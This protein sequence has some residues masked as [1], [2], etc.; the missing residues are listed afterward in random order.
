MKLLIAGVVMLFLMWM[1][2]VLVWGRAP[3]LTE[4]KATDEQAAKTHQSK[5]IQPKSTDGPKVDDA[6][7]MS[8]PCVQTAE[9]VAITYRAF[10]SQH[11]NAVCTVFR[12]FGGEQPP[13]R[14]SCALFQS[15]QVEGI[16]SSRTNYNF[17]TNGRLVDI[18]S[19]FHPDS[20]SAFQKVRVAL[21]Q[22]CGTPTMIQKREEKSSDQFADL[23][24]RL[25]ISWERAGY[26]TMLADRQVGTWFDCSV[27]LNSAFD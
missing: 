24:S 14:R 22:R 10:K 20:D 7:L 21:L 13:V 6:A 4:Q 1:V 19:W 3:S 11:P 2:Y 12:D 5:Q 16:T 18:S 9:S 23:A 27:V 15:V 17:D 8:K 25:R 26:R